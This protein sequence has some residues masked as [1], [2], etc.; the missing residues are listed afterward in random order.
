LPE[1]SEYT[2]RSQWQHLSDVKKES[3]KFD[4][5]VREFY[6]TGYFRSLD[7]SKFEIANYLRTMAIDYRQKAEDFPQNPYIKIP[8]LKKAVR[9]CLLLQRI[10]PELKIYSKHWLTL[11]KVIQINS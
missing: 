11:P 2:G 6:K 9:C 7:F 3:E 8:S 1:L 10:I 5:A 4:L